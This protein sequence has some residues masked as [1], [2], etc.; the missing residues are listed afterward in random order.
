MSIGGSCITWIISWT[1]I[2]PFLIILAITISFYQTR[3]GFLNCK[4]RISMSVKGICYFILQTNFI[5]KWWWNFLILYIIS[6]WIFGK[7]CSLDKS[8]IWKTKRSRTL[9]RYSII[10]WSSIINIFYLESLR[11]PLVKILRIHIITGSIWFYV[12]NMFFIWN[13]QFV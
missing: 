7:R 1:N 13:M 3:V 2:Y 11:S 9:Q 5:R 10:P 12:F 6:I 8:S 4:R